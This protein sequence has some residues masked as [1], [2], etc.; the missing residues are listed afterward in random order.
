MEGTRVH[1]VLGEFTF[2]CKFP[3]LKLWTCTGSNLRRRNDGLAT[4]NGVQLI[5]NNLLHGILVC[6]FGVLAWNRHG[7]NYCIELWIVV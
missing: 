5:L 2:R 1:K 4:F 6:L 3:S 7:S